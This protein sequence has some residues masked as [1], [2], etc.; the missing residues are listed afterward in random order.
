MRYYCRLSEQNYAALM[1][2]YGRK[3]GGAEFEYL[4]VLFFRLRGYYGWNGAIH[5]LSGVLRALAEGIEGPDYVAGG[6]ATNYIP[7]PGEDESDDDLDDPP[8][9]GPRPPKPTHSVPR[10][11]RDRGREGH[12]G[13]PGCFLHLTGDSTAG[14]GG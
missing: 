10:G 7:K 14:V 6:P 9:P 11:E 5:M 4:M 2:E 8:D 13:R 12:E 1:A 3:R